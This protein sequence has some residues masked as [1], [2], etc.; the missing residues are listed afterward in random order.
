MTEAWLLFDEI[1]IRKAAGN[2]NG[3]I[4]LSLPAWQKVEKLPDPKFELDGLLTRA[5]D[6]P[7]SRR[8]KFNARQA[9]VLVSGFTMDFSPPRKLQA[10]Q[11]LETDVATVAAKLRQK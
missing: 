11:R 5:A 6:L 7:A 10:F 2:P 8:R 1:S 4:P 9:A 3:K